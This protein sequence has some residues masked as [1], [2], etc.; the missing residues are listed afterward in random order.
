[1]KHFLLLT[2]FFLV[3]KL[4]LSSQIPNNTWRDH[5]SYTSTNSIAASDEKIYCAAYGGIS[6]LDLSDNS[7]QKLSKV[8][9]LSD[10]NISKIK[11]ADDQD[12][13]IVTYDNGNI[14]IIQ[15]NIITNLTDI[16]RKSTLG[17][18]SIN[19]IEI[20]NDLAYLATGFGIVVLDYAE[21]EIKGTYF[22]GPGGTIICVNDITSDGNTI[23]A[24]TTQGIYSADLSNT[25]LVDYN[26]WDLISAESNYSYIHYHSN[27]L[28]SSL[29][30][31]VE[32]VADDDNIYVF[33]NGTWSISEFDQNGPVSDIDSYGDYLFIIYYGRVVR[34]NVKTKEQKDFWSGG[35]PTG[36]SLKGE[37][38]IW[39]SD[40]TIGLMHFTESN[41]TD[42]SSSLPNGPKYNE[43]YSLKIQD[44]K[45][46]L[47]RGSIT[48][49][50]GNT[51]L[52]GNY[53]V[54][55]DENWASYT[56]ENIRDVIKIAVDPENS[57]QVYIG[58]WGYGMFG[59]TEGELTESFVATNSDKH[60]LQP[61]TTGGENIRI[62]GLTYDDDNNLW[63]TNSGV[64]N[65]ISVLKSEGNWKQMEYTDENKS[66]Y[67]DIISTSIDQKWVLR[68]NGDGLFVFDIGDDID[69]EDD[70]LTKVLS[71]VD[72][73][74]KYYNTVFSIAEDLNGDIWIG[75]N[76]GPVVYYSPQLVF[77][78]DIL[79]SRI[80][81]PRTDGSG[82]ADP[83][84]EHETISAIAIDGA[85]RKWLGTLS[86]GVFLMS[87]DGTEEI[88]NF[89]VDNSPLISNQIN[90]IKIHP[91]T[92]EV[93]IST[94][95]G[96]LSYMG[97]AT[98]GNEYFKDVYVYP[99]PIRPD[100]TGDITITG[101]VADVNVKITD[102]SGNIVFET[103]S[104]GGQA[105][106]D[107]SNYNGE[108]VHTGVYL[109]FCTNDDGSKTHVTK[110]LFIH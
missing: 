52:T 66:I 102:I 90:D 53:S 89:N 42:Y 31:R 2:L 54:F 79:A 22:F 26:N 23:F 70:D 47:T 75:S 69:N 17:D 45:V 24:A 99:N 15:N 80:Y 48:S 64:E 62:G 82:Y 98:E 20:I 3:P 16:K 11:Y 44:N 8:N 36:V 58:T 108:R 33:E 106:W 55:Y 25:L 74:G 13:L 6:I 9:G 88:L 37:N 7:I 81:I 5:F 87:E 63:I 57:E 41:R 73:D 104:L 65:P 86:S 34:F 46:F 43:S 59:Y 12:A 85:N 83:L 95:K 96:L 77:D 67:G 27:K 14:D 21:K 68:R 94:N 78:E 109:V 105:I 51:Y 18:K 35:I 92:G 91:E 28:Y 101:L 103:T 30:D 72:E 107:G 61:Q 93:F 10:V 38:D 100:Y 110:L 39:I 32:G 56:N 4:E 71:I 40:K 50:Y 49:N 1:M 29:Y 84:L 60:T 97:Q 76:E 19:A